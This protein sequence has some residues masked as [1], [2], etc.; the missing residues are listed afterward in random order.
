MSRSA[1]NP[2][3]TIMAG[4]MSGC[5]NVVQ[6]LMRAAALDCTPLA[7]AA[8]L[9]AGVLATTTTVATTVID[10]PTTS[11]PEVATLAAATTVAPTAVDVPTTTSTK[12]TTV[13]ETTTNLPQC[14]CDDCTTSAKINGS[15]N[16]TDDSLPPVVSTD[17][18]SSDGGVPSAVVVSSPVWA[19]GA[20]VLIVLLFLC[21]L[22]LAFMVLKLRGDNAAVAGGNYDASGELAGAE[23]E[24]R[25]IVN[26]VYEATATANNT[27]SPYG[28]ETENASSSTNEEEAFDGFSAN[29]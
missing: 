11:I 6:T 7:C 17:S 12:L 2:F 19:D 24:G 21:V 4:Q 3:S 18:T 20:I 28:A 13:L 23:N 26:V 1:S 8:T 29:A 25:A 16:T 22:V 27:S 9:V 14:T 15:G 10:V 5:T